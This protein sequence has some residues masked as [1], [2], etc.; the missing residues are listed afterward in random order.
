M[1]HIWMYV[2]LLTGVLSRLVWCWSDGWRSQRAGTCLMLACA[3]GHLD[4]VKYVCEVGGKEL[5]MATDTV[6]DL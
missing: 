6:S 5:V 2:D 4:V 1:S 3:R